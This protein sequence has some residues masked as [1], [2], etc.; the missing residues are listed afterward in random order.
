VS[1][2]GENT[3]AT[4]QKWLS[5]CKKNHSKCNTEDSSP[6]W[7]PTRLLDLKYEYNEDPVEQLA[8]LIH[9]MLGGCL[10]AD[11][12]L[13]ETASTS[14]VGPYMTL[15]HRWTSS[16][17]S[18]KTEKSNVEQRK[19]RI[20][21][22]ELPPIFEQAIQFARR[23]GVRYLWIDSLCIIQGD[24]ED[25]KY[26]AMTMSDVYSN[27]FLNLSATAA[28]TSLIPARDPRLID[29]CIIEP[30]WTGKQPISYV[31]SDF[32][33]WEDRIHKS[34]CN[35]RAWITQERW[36]S[37]RVLHFAFDQLVWECREFEAAETFPQGLSKEAK[38]N[39]HTSFKQERIK[40]PT[41]E[42]I[43]SPHRL[44]YYDWCKVLE[45][46]GRSE[47]TY[48]KD[49]LVAIA[50]VAEKL[51]EILNDKWVAGLW[52]RTLPGD[53]LWEVRKGMRT[54]KP[55]AETGIVE[56]QVIG[57]RPA[58]Q[59][60]W[61]ERLGNYQAPS[62]SWA[63][64]LG[65]IVPGV[66]VEQESE[67]AMISILDISVTPLDPKQPLGRLKAAHLKLRGTLYPL[68]MDPPDWPGDQPSWRCLPPTIHITGLAKRKKKP[69]WEG[70]PQYM[71]HSHIA[72]IHP[73][74]PVDYFD[75]GRSCFLP[76]AKNIY[77]NPG[78][79][80]DGAHLVYGLCLLPTGKKKGE[81]QRI[82]R[83]DFVN[84]DCALFEDGLE[85]QRLGGDASGLRA[86]P[87]SLDSSLYEDGMVGV[88][89]II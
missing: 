58:H 2:Y 41:R 9:L 78:D 4:I 55:P 57:A 68:A 39:P 82:G 6:A 27:S 80:I 48:G 71:M 7:Y 74:E 66:F 53:L 84:E 11:V 30:R 49:R 60:N 85:V 25:W 35:Q 89:S 59:V 33:F 81:Y 54:N 15:S 16:G 20:P 56:R 67:D 42:G 37:P 51:S 62:W 75:V 18:I 17:I 52:K 31:I 13:I 83:M 22:K 79:E 32:R 43:Q 34:I 29:P 64:V 1:I 70:A 44:R 10:P 76:V 61:S 3:W 38:S 26:E 47:V 24:E 87:P 63:S 12:R 21:A 88:F 73:D 36:L 14:P 65:D 45:T 19:R 8:I 23:L 5:D 86:H 28:G 77:R 72:H 40:A 50:G 69:L 46:Y